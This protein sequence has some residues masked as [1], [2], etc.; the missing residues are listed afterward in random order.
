MDFNTKVVRKMKVYVYVR[1]Y[2]YWRYD[3][4]DCFMEFD[5]SKYDRM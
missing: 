3:R 1:D 4:L 5:N 2:N